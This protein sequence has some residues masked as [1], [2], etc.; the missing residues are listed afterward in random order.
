MLQDEPTRA[1]I[2]YRDLA[3]EDFLE[4]KR[5]VETLREFEIFRG[6]EGTHPFSPCRNIYHSYFPSP[7]LS[8]M[9][10][11]DRRARSLSLGV[12]VIV[13]MLDLMS[14]S[15]FRRQTWIVY[16]PGLRMS[17]NALTA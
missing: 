9:N 4:A 10:F 7:E 2:E 16:R 13:T 17:Y 14:Y 5:L 15:G 3:V 1:G 11:T 12:T 6:H 8:L